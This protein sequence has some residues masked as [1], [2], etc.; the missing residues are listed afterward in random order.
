MKNVP[1]DPKELE[2]VGSYIDEAG[3]G[4]MNVVVPKLNTPITPK[5]NLTRFLSKEKPCWMPSKNRDAVAMKP[6]MLLDV[7]ARQQ[8]GIDWFGID[9]EYEEKSKAAMVRPGTR[10]LSDITN[11]EKE[12]IWP[13]FNEV[14]W[15]AIND[16]MY[17]DTLSDEQFRYFILFNGLF[18]RTADLTSFADAFTYLV[19][20]PE[21]LNDFL[22]RLAD[23]H[24]EYIGIIKKY[25]NPDMILFHDDMGSQRAPF[26]SPDMFNEVMVP[27]Y[28]RITKAAHDNDMFICLHSCGNVAA[29]LPGFIESGFDI[30]QGQEGP[31][32]K[33]E[34]M[35]KYGDKMP[36]FGNLIVGADTS[37][38][39]AF[40]L[41]HERIDTQGASGRLMLRLGAADPEFLSELEDEM[42]RY[43]RIKYQSF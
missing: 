15:K 16:S 19:T 9:W 35:E 38:E 34:L 7:A 29:H 1:F 42:Y 43:S 36:Q 21:A 10:R 3:N 33:L 13:D 11:W 30:W 2:K 31:T 26:F 32:D 6:P 20:E 5:E 41:L 17:K 37:K 12:I 4:D 24:I 40:D 18:E 39:Q 22:G 28:Q 25:F 8:G 23:W 27:H 14:D